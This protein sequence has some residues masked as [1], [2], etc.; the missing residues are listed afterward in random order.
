MRE[1]GHLS[2]L[3]GLLSRTVGGQPTDDPP[4]DAEEARNELIE[5]IIAESEDESLMERYLEGEEIDTATLITDL[6]K[7]VSRGSFHP[8]VPVCASSGT[9]LPELLELL[10]GGFPSPV[11]HPLPS[12][13]G[14]D[15]ATHPPLTADPA[16]PLAAEVVRTSADA[17]VGRVSLVRVFSGTLRPERTVHVS[18]HGWAPGNG[19]NGAAAD[20]G[21]EDAGHDGDER[22]AHVYSPL[23]ANLREVSSCVAG[24]ICALTKLGSAETGDTVSAS[25]HP[26]LLAP[27]ELP[28]PLLPVA[29]TAHTRGDEDALVKTLARLVAS[30]P[31]LHLERNQETHQMV[32]WCM[33]EAHADVVLSRLR[34]GG[35]EVD[36]EPVRVAMRE[37]LAKPGRATGRHVKQS[38][39]HGQFAVVHIE[40]EPLPRGAGLEFVSKVVGGSVPTQYIPSVEKGVRAQM[41]RGLTEG[42]PVV[43]VRFTL[44]DGKAHSVDSSDAAFQ[45]AGALALREVAAACGTQLLEPVDEITVWI[46]DEHL[47]TVLGD[48]SSRRGRVLGTELDADAGPGR[49]VVHAEVPAVELLRYAVDLRAMTS[50]TAVFTRRFAR[51]DAAPEHARS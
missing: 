47:G 23:G 32:L 41:E 25:D 36:T 40:A 8:V 14:V 30:D 9:G 22:L 19:S 31:T 4:E 44:V 51:Y 3:Y 38:G 28:Q 21:G 27:W 15:G 39:G 7:A 29:I 26:L 16:G 18:G 11:E 13:T 24:D 12:V 35:A 46:P 6:E 50:G 49:T 37:T 34:A 10:V 2:G 48:L 42:C 43:D 5:G 33:G 17:Y 20:H 45:T 1:G